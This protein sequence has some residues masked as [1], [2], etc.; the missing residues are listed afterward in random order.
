MKIIK[1]IIKRM[2]IIFSIF[3]KK[4]ILFESKPDYTDN[5]MAVYNY[6]INNNLD[7]KYKPIWVIRDK[8]YINKNIKTVV[9]D[10][11]KLNVLK[12]VYYNL[13]SAVIVFCN[14]RLDKFYNK[15]KDIYLTH[16][17]IAKKVK[18]KYTMSA[19][20]DY[21]LLQC[22]MMQKPLIDN[23]SL[24]EHTKMIKLGFPRNDDLLISNN[25]DRNKIFNNNFDKMIVWYPTF[26]QHKSSINR[27]VSSITLPV[28]YNETEAFK[29][30]EFAIDNNVLIVLKPHF[31]QDTSYIKN[32][33][34]SN[35]I[36]IDDEFLVKNNLRSYQLL[37][38]SDALITDYS[39]VYYDYLLTDKPI[40]LTWDDFNEY[41]AKEGFAVD[42][43]VIFSG[44]EKIYNSDDFCRFI[45]NVAN[46]NDVLKSERN[47]IKDLTNEYQ[48]SNS[49]KRVA[50]F[51]LKLADEK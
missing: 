3:P 46:G 35:I 1:N 40:G 30:N 13:R 8:K 31:A 42:M 32:N 12:Y 5:S 29:I 48:D 2:F 11:N 44:G 50:E 33:N 20:L 16:G 14:E 38:L 7:K 18:G 21:I 28:I 22:E 15:Q 17:S 43:N 37:N 47:K 51:I 39:S 41:G 4:Y 45:K 49:S 26:R 25:I 6:I 10:S 27:N 34:L 23:L 24:S 36:I 9:Y 19:N